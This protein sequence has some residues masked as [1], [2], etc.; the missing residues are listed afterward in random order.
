MAQ[1]LW[2]LDRRLG[3]FSTLVHFTTALEVLEERTPDQVT[4]RMLDVAQDDLELASADLLGWLS[5]GKNR[6]HMISEVTCDRTLED[7]QEELD[8]VLQR[9]LLRPVRPAVKQT[10]G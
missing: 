10:G 6:R 9:A 3:S 1:Q 5:T 7:A 4:R 2:E 8:L